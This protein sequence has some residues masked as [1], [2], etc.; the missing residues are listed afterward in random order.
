MLRFYI[1]KVL[2]N[3]KNMFNKGVIKN[4]NN[5]YTCFSVYFPLIIIE[6]TMSPRQFNFGHLGETAMYL[7]QVDFP[8]NP[9]L[10]G[11]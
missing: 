11:C 3:F 10:N 4:I 2:R 6:Y 5:N 8:K 7:L 1:Q 9:P